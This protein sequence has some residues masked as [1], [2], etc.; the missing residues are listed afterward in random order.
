MVLLGLPWWLH[1]KQL[2]YKSRRYGFNSWIGKKPWRRKWQ[3]TQVFLSG[4]PMGRGA[5]W[6]VIHGLAKNWT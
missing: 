6:A 3:L 1:N 5:W 4:K 2:A